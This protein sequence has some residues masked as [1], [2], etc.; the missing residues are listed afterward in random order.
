M[1]E[2]GIKIVEAELAE[3]EQYF[4]FKKLSSKCVGIANGKISQE[5]HGDNIALCQ[6]YQMQ[7]V[8]K[9]LLRLILLCS[10]DF[11]LMY[12]IFILL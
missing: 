1:W 7:G 9:F 5:S 3:N 6:Y 4:S 11:L 2:G 10:F 12:L 8:L